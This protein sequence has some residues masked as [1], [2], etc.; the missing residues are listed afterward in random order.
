PPGGPRRPPSRQPRSFGRG[1]S[2]CQWREK[3]IALPC[4]GLLTYPP[5]PPCWRIRPAKAATEPV[6]PDPASPHRRS[7]TP[8]PPP[9]PLA[10]LTVLAA[11][12]LVAPAPADTFTNTLFYTTFQ[13]VRGGRIHSVVYSYDNV[14][15]TF[16]LSAKTD[17]L[18]GSPGADGLIFSADGKSLLIGG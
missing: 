2:P 18:P 13:N 6:L 8:P 5:S 17:I 10:G 7:P 3:C 9:R 14:A 16:G 1:R 11:L 12:L 4:H 15:H